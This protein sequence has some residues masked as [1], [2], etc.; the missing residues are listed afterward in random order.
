MYDQT[1]SGHLLHLCLLL[2]V[3]DL[4]LLHL[5]LLVLRDGRRVAVLPLRLLP[6]PLPRPLQWGSCLG[7]QNSISLYTPLARDLVA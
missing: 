3:L 5:C 7:I 6:L 1:D 4:Q 2:L